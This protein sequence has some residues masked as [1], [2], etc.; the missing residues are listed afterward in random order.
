MTIVVQSEVGWPTAVAR[1]EAGSATTV[2]WS[3][4]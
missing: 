4:R 3:A 1:S 2:V